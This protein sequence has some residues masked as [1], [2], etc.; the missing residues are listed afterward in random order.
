M[1]KR[2]PRIIRSNA[3]P[4]VTAAVATVAA[5]PSRQ[6]ARRQRKGN[7]SAGHPLLIGVRPTERHMAAMRGEFPTP[8]PSDQGGYTSIAR[9]PVG[10]RSLF[11]EVSYAD[12]HRLFGD[13]NTQQYVYNPGILVSRKG[14]VTIDEMRRDEQVKAALTFKKQAV[15]AAGWSVD[16]PEGMEEDDEKTLFVRKVLEKMEGSF[17]RTLLEVLTALDYGFSIAERVWESREYQSEKKDDEE[18]PDTVQEAPD[19]PPAKDTGPPFRRNQDEHSKAPK[20]PVEVKGGKMIW[21]K[22]LKVRRPHT[23]EFAQDPFGNIKGLRQNGRELPIDKFVLYSYDYEFSNPY[24]RTDLE[25]CYRAWWTKRNA[26][27]WLAMLLERLGIPPIFVMYNPNDYGTPERTTMQQILRNLQ[28]GTVGLFPRPNPDS[29]EFWSPELAG[30]VNTVF[31]PAMEKFD[32]DISRALLM[33]GLMGMTADDAQGSL[34]RSKVHFDV[35]MLVLERIRAEVQERVMQEQVIKPLVELNYGVVPE[36]E[37]P[38]FKFLPLTDDKTSELLKDWTALVA[39]QIVTPTD[40]DERYIRQAMEF[41]EFDPDAA[42]ERTTRKAEE[43]TEQQK[44]QIEEG[45]IADPNKQPPTPFGNKPPFGGKGQPFG[46][47]GNVVP[48]KGPQQKRMSL[49]DFEFEAVLD[50]LHAAARE[51][52]LDAT[53]TDDA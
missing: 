5:P 13:R 2:R 25:A 49:D 41:P 36:E 10:G 33:P 32:K 31:I 22:A 18:E 29:A 6:P 42:S 17:E 48:F 8:T 47:K 53:T 28:A 26:Y 23:F 7:G 3:P 34:A 50:E 40:E 1:T 39:G 51:Y 24:G 15:I 30:Q 27:M 35:F 37:M 44:K 4:T 46:G 16:A 11:D 43:Q 14:Y 9:Q 20:P 52:E 45:V 38:Q 21:L 19:K 12:P